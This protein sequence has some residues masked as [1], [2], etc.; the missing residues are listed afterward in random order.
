[1][2]MY[3]SVKVIAGAKKESLKRLTKDRLAVSVKEPAKQNL[4]NKRV[5][6]LVA[7]Y[8]QI[9]AKSLRLISGH[10]TPA[11]LFSYDK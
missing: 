6:E 11:K 10:H 9:P 2:L 7:A 4:A 3:I 1:M 5:T 8:L